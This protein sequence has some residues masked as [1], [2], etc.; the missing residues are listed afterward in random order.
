MST[1]FVPVVTV[2][3]VAAAAIEKNTIV[4]VTIL[5]KGFIQNLL[6]I[7][8]KWASPFYKADRVYA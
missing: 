1:L 6:H 3:A 8:R 7:T 2:A 5:T 4:A